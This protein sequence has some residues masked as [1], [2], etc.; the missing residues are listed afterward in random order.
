MLLVRS[1][2]GFPPRGGRAGGRYCVA[3]AVE[4]ADWQQINI[5]CFSNF[6]HGAGSTATK[7]R[8]GE[9]F[10]GKWAALTFPSCSSSIAAMHYSGWSGDESGPSLPAWSRTPLQVYAL[11]FTALTVIVVVSVAAGFVVQQLRLVV[12][13]EEVA[14]VNQPEKED[15]E[16]LDIA[17]NQAEGP[18]SPVLLPRP[19]KLLQKPF[20]LKP[21]GSLVFDTPDSP[22]AGNF[23]WL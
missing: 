20:A 10:S 12:G 3:R 6:P 16:L 2:C 18:P 17:V 11:I 7:R 8:G 22:R 13:T 14:T 9:G 21:S 5:H 1:K 19:Q 4:V 15:H 23:R